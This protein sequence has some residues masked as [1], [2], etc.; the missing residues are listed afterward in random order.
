MPAKSKKQARFMR[1]V[2]SG[3]IKKKGLSKQ[4]AEEFV[5][6]EPY[7]GLPEKAEKEKGSMASQ[8]KKMGKKPKK[9]GK[10]K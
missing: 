10:A 5:E 2:A 4:K 3:S 6:G 9:K 1:A 8:L 7:K